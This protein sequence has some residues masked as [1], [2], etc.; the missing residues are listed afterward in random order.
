[1]ARGRRAESSKQV[2]TALV[3]RLGRTVQTPLADAPNIH[4]EEIGLRIISDAAAV[5]SERNLA[6]PGRF[7]SGDAD[8]DRFGLHVQAVL[9]HS[10]RVGTKI[11]V[12]P[13]GTVTADD[14]NFRA[15]MS[16]RRLQIRQE[17]VQLRIEMANV[18]R[19][20]VA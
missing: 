10:D 20:M 6:Q 14:V 17:I 19:S 2:G 15:R 11:I 3:S 12:A 16:D 1:M 5:Q 8:V 9:C 4:V 13:G 18:A 7:Y